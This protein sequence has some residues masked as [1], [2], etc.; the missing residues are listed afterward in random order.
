MNLSNIRQEYNANPL[1]QENVDKNPIKQFTKWMND[2]LVSEVLEPTAMVLSTV[3]IQMEISSRVVLLK[4]VQ[5]EKFV[6]FTNYESAKGK[7]LEA[8]PLASLLFFWPQL[9]RQ[10][11]IKGNVEKTS[12]TDSDAYFY[13]RPY[14]SQIS[15][16]ISQQSSVISSREE[17]LTQWTELS[18]KERIDRPKHWG[19]YALKP[20]EIEFWQGR[21]SRLHDRLLY[22]LCKD[23]QWKILR[24]AP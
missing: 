7:N 23:E 22:Q 20:Y 9:F 19:G 17:L 16:A 15:A 12:E 24:L 6:F 8:H 21:N 18:G 13:S 5:Q 10:I 11:R 1:D 4:Y 14:E 2:A 3:N